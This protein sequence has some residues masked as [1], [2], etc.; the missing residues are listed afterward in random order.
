MERIVIITK[1]LMR[2]MYIRRCMHIR[3]EQKRL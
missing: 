1:P 3:R 2:C